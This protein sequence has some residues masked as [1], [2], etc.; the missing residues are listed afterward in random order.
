M[1]VK[2]VSLLI[3]VLMTSALY[4]ASQPENL[5]AKPSHSVPTPAAQMQETAP[6]QEAPAATSSSTSA[7][8]PASQKAQLGSSANSVSTTQSS[9]VSNAPTVGNETPVPQPDPGSTIGKPNIRPV[10]P[11]NGCGCRA[12]LPCPMIDTFVDLEIYCRTQ[13]F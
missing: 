13:G 8:A 9:T 3:S 4:A 5:V 11:V 12:S 1:K 7:S 6:A 10:P 2:L